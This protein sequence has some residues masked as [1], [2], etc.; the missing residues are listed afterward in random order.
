MGEAFR[1]IP[2]FGILR[3]TFQRK[4]KLKKWCLRSGVVLDCI[5]SFFTFIFYREYCMQVLKFEFLE[6]RF[7][8]ILNFHYNFR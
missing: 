8:E 2:E 7:F 3:L 1:I 5:D 4:F 6:F